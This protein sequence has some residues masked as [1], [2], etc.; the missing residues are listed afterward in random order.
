MLHRISRFNKIT[1]ERS[2]KR[3]WRACPAEGLYFKGSLVKVAIGLAQ[4]GKKTLCIKRNDIAKKESAK[5]STER[6]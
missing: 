2:G 5:R 6:L 1:Q 4:K 3:E